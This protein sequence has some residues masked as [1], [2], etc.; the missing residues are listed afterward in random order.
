MKGVPSGCKNSN[1]NLFIFFNSVL[2]NIFLPSVGSNEA[3]EPFFPIL[4]NL[5]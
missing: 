1:V 3:E 5:E 2:L 4:I